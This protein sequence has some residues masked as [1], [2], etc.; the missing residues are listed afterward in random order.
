MTY[1]YTVYRYMND[2]NARRCYINTRVVR[3]T[4]NIE[5]KSEKEI[6][7]SEEHSFTFDPSLVDWPP[8]MS[9]EIGR[10]KTKIKILFNTFEFKS[11]SWEHTYLTGMES[12]KIPYLEMYYLDHYETK[13]IQKT[14]TYTET[15]TYYVTETVTKQETYTEKVTTQKEIEKTHE[16]KEK[17]YAAAL[18]LGIVLFIA[19]A[20]LAVV[21][22]TK[23]DVVKEITP[24][25]KKFCS[26]CGKENLAD[27]AFCINCG[28]SLK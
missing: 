6:Y 10:D 7:N 11:N 24:Q 23:K 22:F 19:G 26:Q 28:A 3:E 13:P 12:S 15:E 2:L 18:W 5:C 4:G 27:S 25:S 8:N 17:P 9:I 16:V 1:V 20:V 21:G 14:V